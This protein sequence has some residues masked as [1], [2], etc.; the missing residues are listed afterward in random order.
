MAL[1]PS[2]Y[3]RIFTGSQQKYRQRHM[4]L[5]FHTA[6]FELA[7]TGFNDKTVICRAS[8]AI[9]L[10]RAK[11]VGCHPVIAST[12]QHQPAAH[13]PRVEDYRPRYRIL[14]SVFRNSIW[15]PDKQEIRLKSAHRS[16]SLKP[17]MP[18]D[19]QSGFSFPPSA[20]T[21]LFR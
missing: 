14:S 8:I 2:S 13:S 3:C 6:A 9:R 15:L 5:A 20:T 16:S 1:L 11:S 4:T 18:S 21:G 19:H 17:E 10:A 12:S 7:A